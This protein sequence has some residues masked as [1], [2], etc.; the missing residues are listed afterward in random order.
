MQT[1]LIFLKARKN[2][3]MILVGCFF[4][5]NAQANEPNTVQ[6]TDRPECW[7]EGSGMRAAMMTNEKLTQSDKSLKR[8]HDDLIKVVSASHS[9][10][11]KIWVQSGLINALT[12]QQASWSRYIKDECGLVGRLMGGIDPWKLAYA[13]KCETNL[14]DRRLVRVKSAQRCIKKFPVDKQIF[15]IENCLQQLAPLV[16]KL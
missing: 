8:A 3:L 9:S 12:E 1:L 2:L 14:V 15:E 13:A 16:N 7:P 6:C 5:S 4:M 11:G 10:D